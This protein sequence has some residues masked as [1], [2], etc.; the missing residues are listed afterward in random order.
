M[1]ER[2][3]LRQACL[4][5]LELSPAS[6]PARRRRSGTGAC[7]TDASDESDMIGPETRSTRRCLDHTIIGDRQWSFHDVDGIVFLAVSVLL[8]LS[9]LASKASARLGIPALLLFLLIGMFS[10]T[11]YFSSCSR[12][13]CSRVPRCGCGALARLG[14]PFCIQ[15]AAVL[16]S[17]I[18]RWDQNLPVRDHHP[19]HVEGSG[20]ADHRFQFAQRS[21]DHDDREEPA[22]LHPH[23]ALSIRA[24]SCSYSPIRR[25]LRRR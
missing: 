14:R 15:P 22:R 12:P 11:S 16:A 6:R 5:P 21:R 10:L 4:M 25:S 17:R 19:T 7:Q 3:D 9:V 1:T 20:E 8:L 13:C 18:S 2:G 23:G 24:T